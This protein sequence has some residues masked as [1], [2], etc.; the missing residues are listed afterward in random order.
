[1]IALQ[2]KHLPNAARQPHSMTKPEARSGAGEVANLQIDCPLAVVSL[3]KEASLGHARLG[4]IDIHPT[5]FQPLLQL[6]CCQLVVQL[7]IGVGR[8]VT[9]VAVEAPVTCSSTLT[10]REKPTSLHNICKVSWK[11]SM[12]LLSAECVSCPGRKV[13]MHTDYLTCA[14]M[15]VTLLL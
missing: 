6:H 5:P 1:M 11:F 13:C 10:V 3:S 8:E 15:H 2:D 9:V 14:C 7:G 4:H 12:K